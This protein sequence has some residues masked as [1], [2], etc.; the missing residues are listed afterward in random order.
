MCSTCTLIIIHSSSCESVNCCGLCTDDAAAEIGNA[1]PHESSEQ[2]ALDSRR[3]KSSSEDEE[4]H[5][6]KFSEH[7]EDKRVT[8]CKPVVGETCGCEQCAGGFVL[9]S[10][11]TKRS[12]SDLGIGLA[13]PGP[14]WH[15]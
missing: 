6:G 4:G 10:C 11:P 9:C 5:E 14:G 15:A 8:K 2:S 3:A 7:R 1:S 13:H 12:V